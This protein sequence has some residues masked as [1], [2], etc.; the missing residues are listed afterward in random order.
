[1]PSFLER[2]GIASKLG[3][4]AAQTG[5]ELSERAIYSKIA[6][7]HEVDELAGLKTFLF[8]PGKMIG[9]PSDITRAPGATFRSAESL[10]RLGVHPEIGNIYTRHRARTEE[11]HKEEQRRREAEGQPFRSYPALSI[12]DLQA[13]M[14]LRQG[15]GLEKG[16]FAFEG[17]DAERA[18]QNMIQ[19]SRLHEAD[20][21]EAVI[22]PEVVEGLGYLGGNQTVKGPIGERSVVGSQNTALYKRR[23][24]RLLRSRNT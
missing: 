3:H 13:V 17:V 24:R 19:A 12:H 15:L 2:P 9:V 7:N 4:L 10:V 8:Y 22:T 14:A 18:I 21:R 11:R 5:F 6:F 1:M 23:A 16:I 20:G